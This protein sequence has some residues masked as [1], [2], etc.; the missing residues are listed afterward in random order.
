M[1]F[2][3]YDP[4]RIEAKWQRRWTDEKTNEPDLAGAKNPFYTLMMFPYPSAEGLHVGNVYAF[5]GADIQGRYHRLKG[6]DV[7]EP[8]GFD[9]FGIHSE[10]FALRVNTHPNKLIPSN[11]ANFR[12][13]LRMMGLMVDWSHEVL[14]TDPHYYRWTQWIFLQLYKYGLAYK[15]LAPVNWCPKCHT[16]ISNE[17]V[18]AGE[19]ERHPGTQVEQKK[20]E[21]WFFR[22]TKYAQK[23]LDNLDWID[24]SETTKTA[25]RNW[26]GRSTGAE[27]DF[28]LV[29]REDHL[30]VYTTRPDTLFGAT[31]M[32]MSP[33]HPLVPEMASPEQRAAVEAYC[34]AAA[35]MK[36]VD[37]ASAERE[38]TG[39][40]LGA[41]ALNPV[42]GH[43]IPIWV[44]DYVLIEYGTGAIM[45]VP[46]HDTRDFEFAQKFNLPIIPVILPENGELPE[47]EAFLAEGTM[48]NSGPYDGLPSQECIRRITADLKARSQGKAA[49]QYRLRDWC[50]SRQRYWGPPIPI[51][52]CAKCGTVPV[53]EDQLP[54]RL[55]EIEDFRPDTPGGKPLERHKPF[56]ETTC[57]SCGGPAH[58][59]SDVSDNFLDS[60][61][62]FLRYPSSHDE[63]QA[64]DP[65]VTRK[66]LPV[67]VYVGG[68]EH[69]VLH[70]MYTRFLCMA[71]KDMGLI[72]FEEPFEK[73][74]AHGLLI[75][76][77]AKMSKTH[78]NVE[79]PD[80]YVEQYGADTLRMYLM[81][82]GP[83]TEGGDFRDSGIIGIRRFLE[84]AHRLYADVLSAG[85]AAGGPAGGGQASGA[86]TDR[87]DLM[88]V[89]AES[90][91][92]RGELTKPTAIKLHQTIKK[93]GEDIEGLSYN[94]AIAALME[95]LTELRAAPTLDDFALTSFPILL[96]PFAPH[97]AEELWE[98]LGRTGSIFSARWPAFD[99][100]LTVEDQV[101]IAVQVLG[102]L[103]GTVT[104]GRDATAEDVRR[105]AEADGRIAKHLAGKQIIKVI[106]VP[107]RLMNFVVR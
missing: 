62:Y 59:D 104:L 100:A 96:A 7:F 43:R 94:T 11:V 37:R 22:I 35:R 105:A 8:I 69:A 48:I 20:L 53:P 86:R 75:K 106:H 44:A 78:G 50:I 80:A 27:V 29:G 91:P 16:V 68:N 84:R 4:A 13:Q 77:G 41:Y 19:C 24:W 87:T 12:R 107:N 38:K 72:D 17:Q 58:R 31:Y 25:Q 28:R 26:I 23:L 81:F 64:W 14:T 103:R 39:V 55:P 79:N 99:P 1:P 85:P 51:V 47:G 60:A 61:W 98:M 10:N 66:W 9:A 90:V 54:L 57:P 74:R 46:A 45:A 93:V 42:N 3:P 63:T 21:Q 67:D 32:V 71:F 56:Y 76:E 30:R 33:E 6:H 88:G 49:V 73:F 82:L 15:A 40:F 5:T 92:V 70:L 95:L 2:E 52:Y 102:K 83:Y 34:Q 97:E 65:A 89:G 101:E 36:A 18:I